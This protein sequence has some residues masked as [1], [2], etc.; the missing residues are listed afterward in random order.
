[1]LLNA[2]Y[3]FLSGLPSA[4][5]H[6]QHQVALRRAALG[7]SEHLVALQL[8]LGVTDSWLDPAAVPF[9]FLSFLRGPS[10]IWVD[11]RSRSNNWETLQG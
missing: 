8:L 6:L 9:E 2:A 7:H 11:Y 5:Q 1:M 10:A 4:H 3:F